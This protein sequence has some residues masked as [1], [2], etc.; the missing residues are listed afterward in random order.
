M[1]S[2]VDSMRTL[3]RAAAEALGGYDIGACTDVT[4]FGLIGHLYDMFRASDVS[5]EIRSADVPLFD[6]VLDMA[7]M[8]MMPAGLYRNRDYVG[9][10]ARRAE[11]VDVTLYEALFDPQT[12]GGLLFSVRGGEADGLV[13]RLR[14]EGCDDACEIGSVTDARE[15]GITVT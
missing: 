13:E 1:A 5:F 10:A 14:R 8:G 4:G 3:N 2:A 7:A 9:E 12:S 11:G 6:G 15:K